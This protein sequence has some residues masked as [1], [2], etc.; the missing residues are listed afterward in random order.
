MTTERKMRRD[1]CWQEFSGSL[2]TV[3]ADLT[4]AVQGLP[5]EFRASATFEIEGDD[6]DD[7]QS[8]Y[9]I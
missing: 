6:Y 4:R 7:G 9:L 8:V 3:V 5:E 1:R 2:E